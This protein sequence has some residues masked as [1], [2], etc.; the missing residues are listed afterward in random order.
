VWQV[1]LTE[2]GRA[3]LLTAFPAT[4]RTLKMTRKLPADVRESRPEDEEAT[5]QVVLTD[6]S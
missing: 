6:P 1:L 3:E 4:T 2:A 5:A